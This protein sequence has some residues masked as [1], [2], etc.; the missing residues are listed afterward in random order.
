MALTVNPIRSAICVGLLL[1]WRSI[2]RADS[3]AGDAHDCRHGAHGTKRGRPERVS[4]GSIRHR[5]SRDND[6]VVGNV[7][8]ERA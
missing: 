5:Q 2:L 6:R 7:S 4:R 8:T 3:R 1:L